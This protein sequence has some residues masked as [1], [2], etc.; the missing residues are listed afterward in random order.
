MRAAYANSL[1]ILCL[2][3]SA[4]FTG[5]LLG[6]GYRRALTNPVTKHIVAFLLLVF[7]IVLTSKDQFI[8]NNKKDQ[9]ITIDLLK[10]AILI[11]A[12]FIIVSKTDFN[13]TLPILCLLAFIMLMNIEKENK[14][15]DIKID[16]EHYTNIATYLAIGLGIFGLFKYYD[17]QKSD[18][19]DD[20]NLYKFLLGSSNCRT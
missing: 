16:I 9:F 11:Y 8:D 12:S 10:N 18:H 6:C 17:R 4:N 15:D 2:T 20:F 5:N 1:G 13:I 19:R 3:I 7:F 14:S